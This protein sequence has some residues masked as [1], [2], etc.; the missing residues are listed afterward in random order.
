MGEGLPTEPPSPRSEIFGEHSGI[1]GA[2]VSGVSQAGDQF[3]VTANDGGVYEAS[4]PG[5]LYDVTASAFGYYSETVKAVEV[6]ADFMSI[7]DLALQPSP[8][9]TLVGRVI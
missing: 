5:G 9:G 4:V 3:V 2:T 7:R 6:I 8:T 1:P